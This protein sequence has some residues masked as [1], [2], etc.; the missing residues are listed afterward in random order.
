M[1]HKCVAIALKE[2][3]HFLAMACSI[4]GRA[5]YDANC[6]F[7]I[8]GTTVNSAIKHISCALKTKPALMNGSVAFVIFYIIFGRRARHDI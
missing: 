6:V 3:R 8:F 1:P 4:V 7:V 5:Q 2:R